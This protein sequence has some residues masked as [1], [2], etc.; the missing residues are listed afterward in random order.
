MSLAPTY[1]QRQLVET[2]NVNSSV[3]PKSSTR[4][5]SASIGAAGSGASAQ[6]SK[7]QRPCSRFRRLTPAEMQVLSE[8]LS[9]SIYYYGP[10][11]CVY[12]YITPP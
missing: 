12:I 1:E 5:A 6:D 9:T 7:T 2:S 8:S 11:E 3:P 10:Y 4:C